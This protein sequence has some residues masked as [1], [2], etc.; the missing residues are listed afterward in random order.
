MKKI[1]C[2]TAMLMFLSQPLLAMD[3]QQAMTVLPTAKAQGLVGEKPDGYLGVVKAEG[4]TASLVQ[5]INTARR[6]EYQKLATANGIK[7]ADVELLAGQKALDKT[8]PG[9]F[10]LQDGQWLKK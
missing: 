10:I 1:V 9:H 3:L 7:L 6:N 2:L 8:Q 4:D 5:L